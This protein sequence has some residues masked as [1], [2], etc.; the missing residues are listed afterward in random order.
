MDSSG[1]IVKYMTSGLCSVRTAKSPFGDD[2]ETVR[3]VLCSK[4]D[5]AVLE[6]LAIG[7][8]FR[9]NASHIMLGYRYA[10]ETSDLKKTHNCLVPFSE[11]DDRTRHY[12]WLVVRN[13][14][15][16]DCKS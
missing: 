14:L 13:S 16:F 7:E 4:S 10:E 12:D 1:T 9:W 2:V 3:I 8:H 5:E 6:Y 15:R 11:L